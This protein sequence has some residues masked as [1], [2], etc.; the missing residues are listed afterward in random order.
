MAGF[1]ILTQ[2]P[3]L[4]DNNEC[5][6]GKITFYFKNNG[7]SLYIHFETT[8][9]Y[10]VQQKLLEQIMDNDNTNKNNEFDGKDDTDNSSSATS[11]PGKNLDRERLKSLTNIMHFNSYVRTRFARILLFAIQICHIIVMVE[12]S[13]IFDSSYISI[14]KSLKA[15]R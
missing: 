2:Y 12:T 13:N 8:F 3:E 10:Y 5:K 6:D 14:F 15:I 4:N 1:N 7:N 11:N 9:D